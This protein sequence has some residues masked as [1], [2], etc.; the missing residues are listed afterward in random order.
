[1]RFESLCRHFELPAAPI[2]A[3]RMSRICTSSDRFR[4]VHVM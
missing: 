1:M 4:V 3:I 2:T